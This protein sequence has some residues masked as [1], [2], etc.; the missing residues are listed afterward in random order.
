MAHYFVVVVIISFCSSQNRTTLSNF[1]L[2]R[3]FLSLVC[4][5]LVSFLP[6]VILKWFLENW[7]GIFSASTESSAMIMYSRF[8]RWTLCKSYFV[9]HKL[10]CAHKHAQ[11]CRALLQTWQIEC[12]F[13]LSY[14]N[15]LKCA[16]SMNLK[17][18]VNID[19]RSRS[20]E[21]NTPCTERERTTSYVYALKRFCL[22]E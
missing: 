11:M 12:F 17:M 6:P 14:H 15:R 4:F 8:C 21:V 13:S 10:N 22:I 7:D 18:K 20:K 3:F 2:T 5:L 16:Y 1:I 19:L 9:V